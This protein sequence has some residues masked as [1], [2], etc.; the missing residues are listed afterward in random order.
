MS[1]ISKKNEIPKPEMPK[2][3]GFRDIKP[4]TN[5]SLS[6]A[7]NFVEQLFSGASADKLSECKT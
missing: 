1:E 6:E 3:A 5:T 4:E 7:K 2:G